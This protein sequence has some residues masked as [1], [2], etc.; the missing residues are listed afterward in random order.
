[1]HSFNGSYEIAAGKPDSK[2]GPVNEDNIVYRGCTIRNTEWII[3]LVAYV[4]PDTKIIKNMVKTK[5]KM[6]F[7]YIQINSAVKGLF[8]FLFCLCLLYAIL[9]SSWLAS[10]L[11]VEYLGAR[12]E[13]H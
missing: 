5:F 11:D 6:S 3:A 7:L 13:T 8:L 9:G 4:G 12:D 1:M 10:R 2:K